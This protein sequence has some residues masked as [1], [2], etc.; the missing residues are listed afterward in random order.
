[1]SVQAE[2]SAPDRHADS[3]V[4]AGAYGSAFFFDMTGRVKPVDLEN[5][6][7]PGVRAGVRFARYWSVQLVWQ[8]ADVDRQAG[9]GHVSLNHALVSA[10]HHYRD[11]RRWGFEPYTGAFVGHLD[12][13][14]DGETLAGFEFGFQRPLG[15]RVLLDLGARPGYSFDNERW[16]GEVY[17]GLNLLFARH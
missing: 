8:E 17:L 1:M 10:R 7:V 6:L 14:D 13:D 2:D 16:D 9:A 3:Y 4:F 11:H 15:T 5:G 12:A